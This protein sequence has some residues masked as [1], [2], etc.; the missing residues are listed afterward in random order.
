MAGILSLFA[1]VF[2]RQRLV[3]QVWQMSV[4]WTTEQAA[5]HLLVVGVF[6]PEELVELEL[7]LILCHDTRR[8]HLFV[9]SARHLTVSRNKARELKEA[10]ASSS[11]TLAAGDY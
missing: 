8:V 11:E 10:S 6:L 1:C 3:R 9:N 2:E 5:G 7:E 4:K